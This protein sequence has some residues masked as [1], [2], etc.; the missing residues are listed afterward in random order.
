MRTYAFQQVDVFTER[1]LA[2]NP[3]AVFPDAAGLSD[4]EMQAIAR[5]MNLSETTFVLPPDPGD[6]WPR[7]RIYTPTQELPFAGHPTIGTA[8]VL[9]TLGRFP[10]GATEIVLHEGVG[11]IPVTLEGDPVRPRFAWMTHPPVRFEPPIEDRAALAEALGVTVDDLLGGASGPP[12]QTG[13]TGNRFLYVPLADRSPVDSIAIDHRLLQR[14]L[15][16]PQPIGVFVFAPE[17]R[18]EPGF[19][20]GAYSRM[21][22]PAPGEGE[23]P[24]TGSA[25]GPLAAYLVREGLHRGP[26]SGPATIRLL[27]EQGTKMRRQSFVHLAVDIDASGSVIAVRVGGA[28][29]PLIT[30]TLRLPED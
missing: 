12:A 29:V 2:G 26:T 8:F 20:G 27:S 17:E 7:V 5:E 30:G 23:D 4:G 6:E 25:S 16:G 19:A 21:V 10:T 15:P 24:A 18:P 1:A 13:T 11:P 3:L 28:T 14:L 22:D 9:A